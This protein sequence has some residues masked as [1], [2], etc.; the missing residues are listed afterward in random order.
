MPYDPE[1]I[2]N[3]TVPVPAL[4]PTALQQAWNGG[5]TLDHLRFSLA[6]NAQRGLASWTAHNI[7]GS[8]VIAEGTIRRDDRFRLDPDVDR[9]VQI[10]KKGHISSWYRKKEQTCPT[11]NH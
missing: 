4:G 6:F 10:D 7:D 5:A 8:D 1:F 2:S 9:I 3:H 11:R